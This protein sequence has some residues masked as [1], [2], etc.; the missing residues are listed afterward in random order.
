LGKCIAHLHI[1]EF[2]KCGLSHAHILIIV[3]SN[4]KPRNADNYDAIV[5]AEIPNPTTQPRLYHT[6]I[7]HMMHSPCNQLNSNAPCMKDGS[8]SKRYPKDFIEITKNGQDSYLLYRCRN[9]KQQITIRGA[10]LDN[11]WVIL[12]NPYL[13][14]KFDCHINIEICSSIKSIK[15]LYKYF[16]KGHDRA[17]LQI[18]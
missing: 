17:S 16:Y 8:C 15:Y 10:Q 2:Q 3:D 6:I 1:I 12:Y 11:R 7:S 4:D 14:F 5:C 13:S 18:T 9:D